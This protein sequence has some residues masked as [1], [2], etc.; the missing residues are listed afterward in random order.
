MKIIFVADAHL[1][2][3]KDP[4][5]ASLV[6]FF[7]GLEGIDLLVVL[8]DLFD[9]W[10]GENRVVRRHY[11]PTLDALLRIRERGI[12]ILYLEG[13]HDFSMGKFF[14]KTL[15][16]DVYGDS[17]EL[18]VEEGKRFFL[19]HGDLI[20]GSVTHAMWRQSLKSG[21]VHLVMAS[22]GPWLV[23][24]IAGAL[25][26]KSRRY[27][28]KK[29]VEAA[30]RNFARRRIA[31]GSDAVVLGHSHVAGVHTEKPDGRTGTYANPGSWAGAKS[32][33]QYEKGKFKLK[34]WKG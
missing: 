28:E 20:A 18:E 12:K 9:F 17:V 3:L 7:D 2:G 6:K 30:L 21:L 32:Y 29:D 33:L 11:R 23:W 1:K 19:A 10:G 24:K 34:R 22:L 4:N 13:N 16:A 14:I 25:S 31:A 27:S 8:G 5:Q 15:E 26:K